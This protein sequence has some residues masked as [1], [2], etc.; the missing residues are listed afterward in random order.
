MQQPCSNAVTRG[1]K[2]DDERHRAEIRRLV[3]SAPDEPTY[4]EFKQALSYATPKEKAELVK[5]VSSFANANLETVGGH[6]YIVFGV[7][8]D[9]RVVGIEDLKGDP[10]STLRQIVNDKL[11][12]AVNFEYLTCKVGEEDDGTKRVAAIVVPD[13]RR[14]PHVVAREIKERVGNR[15]KFWLRRGEVWVRKT[16]GRDLATADDIDEMYEG[17]LR[18]L[19]EERVRPLQVRIEDLERDL[20]EQRSRVPEIGFGFAVPGNSEPMPEGRPYPVIGHLVGAGYVRRETAWAEGEARAAGRTTGFSSVGLGPDA[21]DYERYRQRLEAWVSE[22]DDNL[23]V[24]FVLVNTG[25]AP[26]EDVEV[27]LEMPAGLPSGGELPERP[28]RPRGVFGR[29]HLP[30]TAHLHYSDQGTLIGPELRD[31]AGGET[32]A[33]WEVGKL[34]HD[35]PLLTS[36][37]LEEV[38]GL[39]ISRRKYEELSRRSPDGIRLDY[40]VRAANVPDAHRGT[41]VLK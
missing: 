40:A 3:A 33:V 8:D 23:V 25:R 39:L 22:L 37:E 4:C 11:D 12:R 31:G 26:A 16:G 36:S 20:R 14:R 24:D 19:V 27:T 35:R 15:D 21:D 5:D 38:G 10:P 18:A 17:K 34:Y 29:T 6:G 1:E 2:L 13:S 30:S 32:V 9:G 28:Q 7:S 41:L